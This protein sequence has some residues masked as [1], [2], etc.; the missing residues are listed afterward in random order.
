MTQKTTSEYVTDVKTPKFR[1]LMKMLVHT[2]NLHI[3]P[4]VTFEECSNYINTANVKPRWNT[5]RKE[6]LHHSW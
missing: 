3:T 5:K 1:L 2:N 4:N 6:C